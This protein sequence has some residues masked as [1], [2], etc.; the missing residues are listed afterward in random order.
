MELPLQLIVLTTPSIV[1]IAVK[2]QRGESWSHILS[3]IGFQN[4]SLSYYS[5]GLLTILITGLLGQI[6]FQAIPQAVLT[7]PDVNIS[8]YI[9]LELNL[10]SLIGILLHEAFYIALGE[11]IFFRGLLGGWLFR[12]FGFLIGNLVQSIVFLLPHLLLLLV[13]YS[14]WPIIPVQFI[15]GWLLGWLRYRAQSIFPGWVAHS[16]INTLGALSLLNR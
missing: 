16:I 7:S 9:G 11:E 12:R 15:A 2:R 14:L 10:S 3:K 13:S 4:T 1:Y 6:A 5:L 8:A